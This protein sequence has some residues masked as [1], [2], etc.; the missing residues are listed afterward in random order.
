MD[1]EPADDDLSNDLPLLLFLEDG[2]WRLVNCDAYLDWEHPEPSAPSTPESTATA[3]SS[4]RE[5][6]RV[7]RVIDGDTIEI[8]GGEHVRYIGMDTPESTIEHECFGSEASR[9]NTELVD[10][11]VVE[12]EKD[13]SETDR[14][15]R[16]LRY[17]WLDGELVNEV[18]VREGYAAVST[19]P[20]D[21]KYQ[22]RFLE[23]QRQARS[24]GAGLWSA[25]G[26]A[27]TPI[28][29]PTASEAPG[30]DPAYPDFCIAP[31]PPDL[32]CPQIGRT[33]FTVLPTDPH[34]LDGDGDGVGCESTAPPPPQLPT[35]P[36]SSGNCDPSYPSVCIPSPPPDLDCG[37]ISY[38]RF[39]VLPPD[40][41][42]FDGD[43]DGVGCES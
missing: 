32:D 2:H 23:A 6:V 19:Y 14:Y 18:L 17:V 26:N 15:G 31:P 25:C 21:V 1:G 27:D 43:N 29:Q 9:R 30:C 8:E 7:T 4:G 22:D 5:R 40:P 16:L 37:Q 13:V 35:Q 24:E 41:H 38:R 33:G 10:G 12:L 20:P 28:E 39:T 36:P 34:R 11:K 42:G 3:P